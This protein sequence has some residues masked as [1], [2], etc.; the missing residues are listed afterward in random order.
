MNR[1]EFSYLLR[2]RSSFD[3]Y[4]RGKDAIELITGGNSLPDLRRYSVDMEN[5]RM[6]VSLSY[7]MSP[8]LLK[9]L[10]KHWVVARLA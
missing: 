10:R 8:E 7:K 4:A 6:E 3:M 5:R 1:E 9:Q 2:P